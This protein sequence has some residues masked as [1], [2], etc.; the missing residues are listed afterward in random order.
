[1]SQ[2]L[3]QIPTLLF[4]A[5]AESTSKFGRKAIKK[6]KLSSDSF[7]DESLLFLIEN[8]HRQ[9]FDRLINLSHLRGRLSQN[10]ILKAYHLIINSNLS[11]SLIITLLNL[12]PQLYDEPAAGLWSVM[13]NH[14]E[15]LKV[16]LKERRTI[17]DLGWISFEGWN[18]V[19]F[20]AYKGNID[21]L[22][23]LLSM[24]IDLAQLSNDGY[25]ALY[26]AVTQNK[27]ETCR[28]L[29]NHGELDP[30]W[31]D[32]EN[33]TKPLHVAVFKGFTAIV[34][35][36]IQDTRVDVNSTVNGYTPL[37]YAAKKGHLEI[38]KILIDNE[39]IE[40]N[41]NNGAKPHKIAAHEGFVEIEQMLLNHPKYIIT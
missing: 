29:L 3:P 12:Y 5:Y 39:R 32:Y 6:M 24:G 36:L 23:L 20:A 25:H 21:C 26:L 28:F 41:G 7:N 1:M 33:V 15:L 4:P 30:D 10:A 34:D 40:I 8:D 31:G 13:N 9:E 16:L 22:K 14:V 19:H 2:I 18:L 37:C 35:L 17:S 27:L 11:P 38:A